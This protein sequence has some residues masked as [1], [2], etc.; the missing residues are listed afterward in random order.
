MIGQGRLTRHRLPWPRA[1]RFVRIVHHADGVSCEVIGVERRRPVRRS[2]SLST[3]TTLAS[4]GTPVVVR[5]CW[6]AEGRT[7][8]PPA[9]AAVR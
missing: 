4:S 1:S 6:C 7:V 2:V 5:R 3:A 8:D 9:A